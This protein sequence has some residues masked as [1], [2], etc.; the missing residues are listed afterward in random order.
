MLYVTYMWQKLNWDFSR[1]VSWLFN[2]CDELSSRNFHCGCFYRFLLIWFLLNTWAAE[3]YAVIFYFIEKHRVLAACTLL[4]RSLTSR[5]IDLF[6]KSLIWHS[7]SG[8]CVIRHTRVASTQH[9]A[10]ASLRYKGQSLWTENGSFRQK[11]V[12]LPKESQL[13]WAL[14]IRTVTL[15]WRSDAFL[16]KWRF[17]A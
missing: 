5:G 15:S 7:D 4:L 1:L 13:I 17:L 16:T 14:I 12:T 2:Y 11:S 10:K 9:F 6:S 8:V 3:I